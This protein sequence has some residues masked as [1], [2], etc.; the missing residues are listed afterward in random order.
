MKTDPNV[1]LIF[2]CDGVLIDSEGI[3][4]RIELEALQ[5]LG[6]RLTFEEYLEAALGR[7]EEEAVWRELASLSGIELPADFA[8]QTQRIVADA[9]VRE[10]H[11]IPGVE[12]VLERLSCPLCVASGSRPERLRR[13]LCLT[14]LDRFFGENIFSAAQ[15]PRGKPHPDL[16]LFAA[17]Q[18]G[19]RP[20]S[21]LVVE[22]SPAGVQGA[23]AAGMRVFGFTGGSHSF[24]GLTSRLLETGV[25]RVF[26]RMEQLPGLLGTSGW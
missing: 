15:V 18:M 6:C 26:D 11:A 20:E 14:R 22:D 9:F 23:R 10:L 7:T 5:G 13:N 17:K 19:V 21:C 3:G 4:A 24:P 12:R 2:D 1:V 8:V 16:F 25:E